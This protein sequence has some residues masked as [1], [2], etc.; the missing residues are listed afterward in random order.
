MFLRD[1]RSI[2]TSSL[3]FALACPILFAIPVLVEFAQHVVELEAGMYVDTA[4]A[5]VAEADPLRM[6]FGLAKTLALLLPGYWFVR[7]LLLG[8]DARRAGRIEMPAFGLWFAIF[9][10]SALRM[11]LSLFGPTLGELTGL[12]EAV[13]SPLS[14]G[15]GFVEMALMIYLAVWLVAWP[16]GNSRL[17]PIRSARIMSGSF[18]YAAGLFVAGFLPLMVVHYGLAIAAVLWL[19]GWADWLAMIA[20]SVVVGFL[21]LTMTGATV[22]GAQRAAERKGIALLPQPGEAGEEPRAVTE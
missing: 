22:L 8:R 15:L 3:A 20:D 10:L 19:P 13:A 7:Y 6:E 14:M 12:D 5:Q 16:V 9:S 2:F 21:A 4:S 17:G 18:W 11:W 1:I